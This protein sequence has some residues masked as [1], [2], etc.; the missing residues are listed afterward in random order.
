MTVS[1][2]YLSALDQVVIDFGK[3]NKEQKESMQ[4]MLSLCSLC[5]SAKRDAKTG[6]MHGN[7][8]DVAILKFV[9]DGKQWTNSQVI[10]S[11][12]IFYA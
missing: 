2:V 10:L 5:N 8:T 12:K 11:K 9:D 4:R 3:Q 7:A 1:R 6:E